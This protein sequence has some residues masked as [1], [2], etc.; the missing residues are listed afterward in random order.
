MQKE[1]QRRLPGREMSAKHDG[2]ARQGM[3]SQCVPKVV[4]ALRFGVG[5][6]AEAYATLKRKE[7]VRG[8]WQA[9]AIVLCSHVGSQAGM[10][11]LLNGDG[12][13]TD[14]AL[15]LPALRVIARCRGLCVA[16]RVWVRACQMNGRFRWMLGVRWEA[17]AEETPVRVATGRTR[18][19]WRWR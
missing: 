4:T 3:M 2:N 14:D 16:G 13:A 5:V 10:P 8:A 17:Q 7:R 11:V 9:F 15:R 19:R 1:R 6:Q 12:F 18:V